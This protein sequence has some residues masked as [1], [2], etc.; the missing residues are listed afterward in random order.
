MLKIQSHGAILKSGGV[1]AL[2]PHPFCY[3]YGALLLNKT[4]YAHNKMYSTILT[5]AVCMNNPL[6]SIKVWWLF[7]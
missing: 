2:E 6:S 7:Y 5:Y 3:L 4:N 1:A